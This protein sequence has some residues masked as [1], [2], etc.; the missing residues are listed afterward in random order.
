M[1]C[2][3]VCMHVCKYVCMYVCLSVCL[4]VCMF[5]CLFVSCML[6]N[7]LLLS[8]SSFPQASLTSNGPSPRETPTPTNSTPTPSSGT[9]EPA[10]TTAAPIAHSSSQ[11]NPLP[12][13]Q[14]LPASQPAPQTTAPPVSAPLTNGTAE[15]Q[16]GRSDVGTS[17]V[18]QWSTDDVQAWLATKVHKEPISIHFRVFV[19][20]CLLLVAVCLLL[21]VCAPYLYLAVETALHVSVKRQ[22]TGTCSILLSHISHHTRAWWGLGPSSARAASMAQRY[23]R[24]V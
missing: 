8:L 9:A 20:V 4:Y 6:Y 11:S 18:A 12:A 14:P 19:A 1:T 13:T 16:R 15:E 3:Y 2:I 21:V 22:V 10:S 17:V 7:S 5:V 24:C 23:S